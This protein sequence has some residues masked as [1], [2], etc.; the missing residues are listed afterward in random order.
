MNILKP[1]IAAAIIA[2][3]TTPAFATYQEPIP[4]FEIAGDSDGAALL[5]LLGIGAFILWKSLENDTPQP[6]MPQN[7]MD[8][9]GVIV[10]C[11]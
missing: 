6:I 9:L 7:C 3:S 11:E 8:K 1:T 4:E 10:V 5:L 2:A